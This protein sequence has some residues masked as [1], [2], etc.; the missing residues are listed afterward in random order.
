MRLRV[1]IPLV[2]LLI[3][4]TAQVRFIKAPAISSDGAGVITELEVEVRDGRGRILVTTEPLVG[5]DTQNSEKTAVHVAQNYTGINLD[6]KDIIF[7]FFADV[8]L[9]DGPSA[10]AGM[11][12]ATIAALTNKTLNPKVMI[13][14]AINPD[15]TIGTVG[16]ILRKAKVVADAGATTFLIPKGQRIQTEQVKRVQTPGPG[17]YIETIEPVTIDIT[18]YTQQWGLNIIEVDNV[19]DAI[20][21]MTGD[22]QTITQARKLPWK[23]LDK[24]AGDDTMRK[25][26]EREIARAKNMDINTTLAE[27]MF[28][29]K[30]YYTAANEAFQQ[31]IESRSKLDANKLREELQNRMA[32]LSPKIAITNTTTYHE[33]DLEWIAAAQ[34]RFVQASGVIDA[35]TSGELAAG[36]EWLDLTEF[37]LEQIHNQG[38]EV[39]VAQIRRKL[40]DAVTDASSKTMVAQALGEI[41]ARNSLD[42]AVKA[43]QE[44]YYLGAL[45]LAADASAI[46]DAY[47]NLDPYIELD[48]YLDLQVSGSWAESYMDHARYTRYLAQNGTRD[49]AIEALYY[50][51]RAFRYSSLYTYVSVPVF[52]MPEN[53]TAQQPPSA[54]GN[55]YLWA[56]AGAYILS[57]FAIYES[58]RTQP[59][60]DRAGIERIRQRLRRM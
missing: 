34:Q 52:E 9:V 60:I 11:A 56:I 27:S 13:T 54:S 5:V 46:S 8:N 21:Y 48:K 58:K 3:S 35:E 57:L 59:S 12:T 33:P 39:D 43:A 40:G 6:D 14:G 16:G 53:N 19:A 25:L 22:N 20:T 18:T 4:V 31:V 29:E 37:C 51:Q 7:T 44:G 1:L 49:Q 24:V 15:G 50:S 32:Q 55:R 45:N 28:D 17:V 2:L 42:L 10:G 26:A 23:S 47:S 38:P 41:R 36:I 30:Y